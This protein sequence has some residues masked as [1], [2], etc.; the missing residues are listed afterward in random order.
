MRKP[1]STTNVLVPVPLQAEHL[2]RFIP[3]FKPVPVHGEQSTTGVTSIVFLAPL[4][5]SMNEIPMV[6][7]RSDPFVL[8]ERG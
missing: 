3:G 2:V 8:W 5:A 6:D 7:S 4:H 1:L